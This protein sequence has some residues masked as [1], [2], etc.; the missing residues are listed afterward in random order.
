MTADIA[1]SGGANGPIG[2]F[3]WLHRP[4]LAIAELALDGPVPSLLPSERALMAG[5]V[6]HRVREF[7]AGRACARRALAALGVDPAP[8]GIASDRLPEW[9]AEAGGSITHSKTHCAAAVFRRGEG[10]VSVGIDL[11]PTEPLDCDLVPEI[12]RREEVD[13]LAQHPA[14]ERLVLARAIFSAKESA[15]KC[16]YSVSRQ[17][18]E[19]AD[20]GV[21]L[22]WEHG[23]FVATL[24]RG[25]RLVP[26]GTR[27]SGQIRICGSHIS[28]AA[29]LEG[30]C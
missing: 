2:A 1:A 13:W 27:I 9:P 22:L 4:G 28:S 10:I 7:A 21:D 11:E 20:I 18:L 15:Y 30:R 26:T 12:C 24:F 25:N 29:L 5:A 8:I 14:P 6:P 17:A 3:S 16:Q 23:A 19:F